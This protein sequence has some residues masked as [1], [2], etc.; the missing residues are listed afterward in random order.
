MAATS[1]FGNA[2]RGWSGWRDA[3][4]SPRDIVALTQIV[5]FVSYQARVAAG[6]RAL[7]GRSAGDE[8]R[9]TLEPVDWEPGCRR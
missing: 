1:G 9:F 3:G 8:P 5:A 7:G 6:L 4:L 2:G